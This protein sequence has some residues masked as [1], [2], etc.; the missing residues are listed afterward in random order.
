MKI[1]IT[2]LRFPILQCHEQ[3]TYAPT[4]AANA[5]DAPEADAADATD[6]HEAEAFKK[7]SGDIDADSSEN[8]SL[9]KPLQHGRLTEKKNESL[10]K[11]LQ[12]VLFT[13]EENDY[14]PTIDWCEN[15]YFELLN[16]VLRENNL[17]YIPRSEKKTVYS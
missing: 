6:V 17:L 10:K 9:K 13:D 16:L 11:P 1:S 3:H 12:D 5:A 4:A 14:M 15:H 7:P 2:Y 8:K